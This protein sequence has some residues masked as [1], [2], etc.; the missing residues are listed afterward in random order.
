MAFVAAAATGAKLGFRGPRFALAPAEIR[1]V[2]TTRPGEPPERRRDLGRETL[3]RVGCGP[4]SGN[5]VSL[6]MMVCASQK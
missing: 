2:L 3:V 1:G 5:C 4:S 6:K